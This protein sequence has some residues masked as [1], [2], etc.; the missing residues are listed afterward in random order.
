MTLIKIKTKSRLAGKVTAVLTE[1]IPPSFN[2]VFRIPN[3]PDGQTCVRYLK[4]YLNKED[5]K[6]RVRFRGP[7]H[8]PNHTLKVDAQWFAIYIDKRR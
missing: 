4:Q 7:R 2:T 3:D 1:G 5:Y 8:N 6:L